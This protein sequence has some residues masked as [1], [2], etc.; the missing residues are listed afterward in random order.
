MQNVNVNLIEALARARVHSNDSIDG[1]NITGAQLLT[2]CAYDIVTDVYPE[3]D[4]RLIGKPAQAFE[5]EVF[6]FEVIRE[7]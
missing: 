6:E 1:R 3:A 2:L 7:G 5:A 4:V